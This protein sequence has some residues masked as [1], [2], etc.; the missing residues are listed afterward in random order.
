VTAKGG[1]PDGN[2]AA[3]GSELF[4]FARYCQKLMIVMRFLADGKIRWCFF[5][6]NT[7]SDRTSKGIW[8]GGSEEPPEDSDGVT[9]A[10]E[11]VSDEETDDES[12]LEVPATDR[13]K[14]VKFD[15]AESTSEEEEGD[16]ESEQ[17]AGGGGAGG[18]FAA[19][20]LEDQEDDDDD[21]GDEESDDSD[22]AD[23]K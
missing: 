10:I 23:D 20:Q 11:D 4:V 7:T 3:N 12:D 13:P 14:A 9:T 15:V 17:E 22:D 18:F 1:R 2:R 16:D 19:L 6:P 21:E 5:P 8:L